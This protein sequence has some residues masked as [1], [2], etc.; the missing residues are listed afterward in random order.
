VA[1]NHHE[2]VVPFEAGDG[3]ACN[4][5]H[6]QG[7]NP[8]T[9]GPVLLVHGAGVRANLFR[10]PVDRT[11]V[12]HLIDSGY[13][14]WLENWR[15]SIDLQPNK[16]NL[17]QA[18]VFDHPRAVKK[19][20]E[21]TGSDTIKAV[22]HCQ[23]STS[24]MMSAV[25]G[26]VP[27]VSVIVTNAV[28]LHPVVPDFSRFK[29]TKMMPLVKKAT[30]YLN[31]QWGLDAPSPI[32]EFVAT[33]VGLTHHECNNPVCKGV[34]FIYGTGFPAL[35]SHENLNDATH[36]WIKQEFAQVPITFF[37]QM[38]TCIEATPGSVDAILNCLPTLSR[39]GSRRPMPVRFLRRCQQPLLPRRK[40]AAHLRPLRF[41]A[42]GLSLTAH[43]PE[44]RPP[45]HLLRK[46][47]SQRCISLD[48]CGTRPLQLTNS[49]PTENLLSLTRDHS[50]RSRRFST[51][52]G[53]N[54]VAQHS[55][56]GYG[57]CRKSGP[58]PGMAC[59]ARPD[60]R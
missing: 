42:Q 4:L 12:D 6:V 51:H 30:D 9:K 53:E 56:R 11:I 52:P 19:V 28:S 16:W 10:A 3:F 59:A 13:D 21:Q 54:T 45:R 1:E 22:I 36:E 41:L 33:F 48:Q 27:E 46:E 24:F 58:E 26:L 20:V 25:A 40:P 57:K 32:A 14:V 5:I 34:S 35:W 60:I 8:P 37:E 23:G 18:A 38:A 49:G 7:P 15:D 55:S 44:L 47:R 29:I 2:T 17:D 43:D 39:A 31:P 50:R